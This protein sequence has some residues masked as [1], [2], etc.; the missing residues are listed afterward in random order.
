MIVVAGGI[1]IYRLI[2]TYSPSGKEDSITD[3]VYLTLLRVA[4]WMGLAKHP[5]QTPHEHAQLLSDQLPPVQSEI[6]LITDAYVQQTFSSKHT[7]EVSKSRVLGAWDRLRP[8]LYRATIERGLAKIKLPF[9][10]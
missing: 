1:V 3:D 2:T 10:W 4:R 5:S 6:S 9:K 7:S 8:K